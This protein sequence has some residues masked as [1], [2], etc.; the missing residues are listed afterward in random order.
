[1][2]QE[3]A[4]FNKPVF[5]QFRRFNL[6]LVTRSNLVQTAMPLFVLD[7]TGSY[8]GLDIGYLELFDVLST[9]SGIF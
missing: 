5:E 8:P 2:P 9:P 4:G 6:H 3:P 7:N 1:M